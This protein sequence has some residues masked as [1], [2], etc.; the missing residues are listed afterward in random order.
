MTSAPTPHWNETDTTKEPWVI[1]GKTVYP[2]SSRAWTERFQYALNRVCADDDPEQQSKRPR[3]PRTRRTSY[4][5]KVK[6]YKD[7]VMVRLSDGHEEPLVT[8][9]D[10]SVKHKLCY[11]GIY[12]LISEPTRKTAYGWTVKGR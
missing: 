12:S 6:Q 2:L 7:V 10:F 11:Q 3:K 9:K 8:V 5:E 1:E 4:D